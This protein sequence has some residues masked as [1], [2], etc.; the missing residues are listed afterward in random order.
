M[1]KGGIKVDA[2]A[3]GEGKRT[4][5][6]VK[7]GKGERGDREGVH[8]RARQ[9][10]EYPT[11]TPTFFYSMKISQ[12]SRS[13]FLF[14]SSTAGRQAAAQPN[15]KKTVSALINCRNVPLMLS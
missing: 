2:I 13:K 10:R 9:G 11:W 3:K 15:E 8:G 12:I 14:N 5:K 7:G 1:E 4:V 6:G